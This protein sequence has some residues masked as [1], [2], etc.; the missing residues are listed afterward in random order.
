MPPA[1]FLDGQQ[2]VVVV[3]GRALHEA[4]QFGQGKGPLERGGAGNRDR[5]NAPD[6]A[7]GTL[8]TNGASVLRP[9]GTL[10]CVSLH[11]EIML[12]RN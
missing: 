5:A 7:I 4:W 1:L 12:L 3:N 10:D 6:A 9:E 11:S 2:V 8:Q